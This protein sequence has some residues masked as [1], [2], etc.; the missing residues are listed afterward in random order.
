MAR[1]TGPDEGNRSVYTIVGGTWRSAAG[2]TAT[3]YEDAEATQ[4][5]DILADPGG[6]PIVDAELT[7]DA[8]SRIPTFQFP[9]NTDTVYAQVNGGP[10]VALHVTDA[11]STTGGTVSGTLAVDGILAAAGV[12]T[13]TALVS[14]PH[15]YGNSTRT[16]LTV[17]SSYPTDDTVGGTDGTGRINLYSYQRAN[18]YSFG[19]VIRAFMMR[20]DS[21]QMIAWYAPE[22]GFDGTSRDPNAGSFKPVTWVG[23]HWESNGHTGNHKHWEVEIPDTTGALHGRLE[24]L[25]G[26]QGD[27][28][29]GLEKTSIL[30]NLAD[31]VVRCSG[32]DSG[33]NVMQQVLRLSAAAGREKAIEFAND[34]DGVGRRFKLRVTSE[35]ESGS[36][37]GSNFQVAR[38]DD[39]GTVVDSPVIISRATGLVTIGGS[40][41]TSSGLVISSRFAAGRTTINSSASIA[42]DS[43]GTGYAAFLRA[44]AT[45]TATNAVLAIEA[46][47]AATTKR[48]FDFRL[49][50]D[51]V[52]RLRID[53]S[54]SGSGTLVFGDGTSADTNLYRSTTDTLKT[55]DSLHVGAT[56]RHLGSSVGFFNAAATTKPTVSGSRDA[57]AALASLLT[58]LSTLGLVTDS[59]SV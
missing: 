48:A 28:T 25:F 58:A 54:V 9:D 49:T 37:A 39:T 5:A 50:G 42:S 29:I 16:G 8:Y 46:P 23:T 11:V 47:T 41:A 43:D 53:A 12:P 4:V 30:T 19:E 56:L 44:T 52:S 22:N 1:L 7:I 6:G 13:P 27:E 2:L 59:T 3:I 20:K 14:L 33:G 10:T 36:G 38:Y 40:S 35:A 17:R 21:K 51:T 31:L 57:N 26:P 32:T 45:G 34:V 24:I 55:D 18:T 15:G